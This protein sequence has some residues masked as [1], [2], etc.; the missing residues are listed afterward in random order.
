[1]RIVMLLLALLGVTWLGYAQEPVQVAPAPIEPVTLIFLRHAET[2]GDTSSGGTDPELSEAGQ[3][4]AERLAKLFAASGVTHVFSSE[5][6]RTQ[7]TVAVLAKQAGLE[8]KVIGARAGKEQLDALSELAPGSVAIVCGHSNTTPQLVKRMGGSI[9]RLEQG[10]SG[11]SLAHSE[12]G[13]VFVV[14]RPGVN[15]VAIST[16]ELNY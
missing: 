7:S 15:G 4:R 12:Y 1:M 14:T 16:M 10:R 3:A 6:R 13:R 9:A 2:A 8:T 5:Y 11:P